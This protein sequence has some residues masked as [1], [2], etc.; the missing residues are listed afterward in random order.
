MPKT[1]KVAG[2]KVSKNVSDNL[3][4]KIKVILKEKMPGCFYSTVREGYEEAKVDELVDE[5][6]EL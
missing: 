5:L 2:P 6:T 3:K 4:E 1:K